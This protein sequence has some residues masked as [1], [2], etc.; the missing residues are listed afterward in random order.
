MRSVEAPSLQ[1]QLL[2]VPVSSPGIPV[3]LLPEPVEFAEAHTLSIVHGPA[4]QALSGEQVLSTV[5]TS[6][7]DGSASGGS[8]PAQFT[9][10]TQKERSWQTLPS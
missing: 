10:P 2:S 1:P 6:Y 7:I 8:K 9:T 3:E 4:S 5:W